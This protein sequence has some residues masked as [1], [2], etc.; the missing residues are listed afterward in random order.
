MVDN[1]DFGAGCRILQSPPQ[2]MVRPNYLVSERLL[3]LVFRDMLHVLI[4]QSDAALRYRISKQITAVNP[5]GNFRP[6]ITGFYST[7]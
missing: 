4:V 7:C 1:Q 6:Y 3:A 5:V 2:A